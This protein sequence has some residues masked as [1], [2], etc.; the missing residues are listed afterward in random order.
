ML[1]A[2]NLIT[3]PPYPKE[4]APHFWTIHQSTVAELIQGSRS[5]LPPKEQAALPSR[6]AR[7]WRDSAAMPT[8]PY[9]PGCADTRPPQQ[10][11][12]EMRIV[13]RVIS[14]F[15]AEPF[16]RLIAPEGGIA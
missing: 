9:L 6:A 2:L 12:R 13:T 15:F 11:I 8:A 3:S 16:V 10:Y 14:T 5:A 1:A 4:H 7:G